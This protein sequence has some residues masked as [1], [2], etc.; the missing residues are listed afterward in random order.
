[1]YFVI[2]VYDTRNLPVYD[3]KRWLRVVDYLIVYG[4]VTTSLGMT[5]SLGEAGMKHV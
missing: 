1:M 2:G 4:I 5:H 3:V